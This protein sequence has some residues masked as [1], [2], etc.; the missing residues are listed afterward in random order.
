[1]SER[2]SDTT[3]RRAELEARLEK[4][5][6]HRNQL[7]AALTGIRTGERT[8]LID[9]RRRTLGTVDAHIRRITVAL[10]RSPRGNR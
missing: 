8:A 2:P 1:V 9:R 4:L 3:R 6:S 7:L 10:A 5:Q